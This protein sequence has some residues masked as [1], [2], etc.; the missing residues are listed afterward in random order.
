MPQQLYHSQR[1]INEQ[2]KWVAAGTATKR[3]GDRNI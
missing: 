1:E 3:E 2:K